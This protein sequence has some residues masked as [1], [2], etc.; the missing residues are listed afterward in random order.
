MPILLYD[1]SYVFIQ[2]I[3]P[4]RF[5]QAVSVFYAENCLDMDLG[6]CI[7]HGVLAILSFQYFVPKGTFKIGWGF[8]TNISCLMAGSKSTGFCCL[9]VIQ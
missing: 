9:P 8:S 6:E 3:L 7:G 1:S 5:N 4:F 2:L